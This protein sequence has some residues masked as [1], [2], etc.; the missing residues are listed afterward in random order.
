[1][2]RIPMRDLLQ[3]RLINTILS[4]HH[5]SSSILI[6]PQQNNHF[7]I[8]PQQNNHFLSSLFLSS[9]SSLPYVGKDRPISIYHPSI[10]LLKSCQNTKHLLQ[11]QSKLITC[12]L[13]PFWAARL[14][15]YYSDFGHIHHTSLV[16]NYIDSPGTFC[17]N[18]VIKAYSVSSKP[19]QAVVFYFD[20]LKNGFLPNSYT[21][22]SLFG[23]C[24]KMGCLQSGQKCHGQVLKNGVDCILPVQNSLIHFYG[25]CGLVELAR[26]VFDEMSQAD[27]VS[28][29]S[30]V[31]AY[32]NVGELDTAHDIFNIMLGKTVV[33]WNVMIYGYLKG[34]NP[35][36]SLMLFRKMVNSGL[37]GN[38][39]TMVSVLSA[40]GKSARL[41]EGRSIHGFLI[42]T[43]LNFSVILLTSLMDM[44]SKCQK[45]KL[46]R[47]I[48]DS[49]VHRNLICWNAMI[50]GHCIHGK[51]ADGLD[52]FAEMVNSTGETILPDEVTYI[53]VIS[54]CARAGLLTEGRKFFSQMM[55]KYTIKPNFAH[56]WC[57]ANLYAGVGLIQ[58]AENI[59][60]E[61]P[62]DDENISSESLTWAN[63]LSSCR[64]QADA[65]LGER[66]AKSLIDME[67]QN[68]L[69]YR[70]LLNIYAVTGKWDDVARVRGLVKERRLGRIPGCHLVD[71]KEIV[72]TYRVGH[73]WQEGNGETNMMIDEVAESPSM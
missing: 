71:L 57:M 8:T 62:K 21:F 48:F 63:L 58:E 41:T 73:L 6:T 30:I 68:F 3:I 4:A 2:A 13:F 53:G 12:G 10:E 50:L 69:H 25:C 5:H 64:F 72:H 70:L 22:V 54:A 24:A 60:V 38:D 9:Y 40:C 19:Q 45:V 46:A 31:N 66:I 32:A 65:T 55:D 43:S 15:K 36:C 17:V 47:S 37:R 27:L 49:M 67:P 23:A 39:K 16:F 42:R 44:Y 61:M 35:G 1:M 52:L 14:L 59:L 29:N 11:I 56:Y 26:K 28:W 7:L 33:S 51:P 18:N 20:M 34:N